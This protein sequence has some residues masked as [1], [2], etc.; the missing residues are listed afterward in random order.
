MTDSERAV[1]ANITLALLMPA[2]RVC[3]WQ[4]ELAAQIAMLSGIDVDVLP[5]V[6]TPRDDSQWSALA[7]STAALAET[8]PASTKPSAK[9]TGWDVVLDLAGV[10][11]AGWHGRSVHGVWQLL[12]AQGVAL[13]GIFPAY[14]AIS[15]GNG[16]EL[17]LVRDGDAVLNTIRFFGDPRY[18]DA[19]ARLYTYASILVCGPLQELVATGERP[20]VAKFQ[21]LPSLMR[22]QRRGCQLRQQWTLLRRR[23]ASQF[24]SESWMIGVIDA[25][26]KDLLSK[27]LPWDVKW[28]GPRD[29]NYYRADPFGVPG[30]DDRFYCEVF[31]YR[32][33]RGSLEMI[34][35]DDA[36]QIAR[37]EPAQLSLSGH[38]SYPYLFEHA[39]RTYGIPET[40]GRN[41][42]E[43][44][45]LTEDGRWL[46][47]ATLLHDVA[48]IDASLFVWEGRFWLAYTDGAL[49][50]YNNLCL[51]YAS[52]LAGPW[53]RH[54][55][56]P[57]K[58]DHRSSRS[59]GTPF[60]HG[61]ALY[62]PAQDCGSGYGQAVVIN[63]ITQ[64]TP[65]TFH[66][67][68]VR[69]CSP[70]PRG[71]NPDGLHTLSAWGARTLVD[72][73]KYIFSPAELARKLR[74]RIARVSKA[75]A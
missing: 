69:V 48:A 58:M 25:P 44:F 42:C 62:R 34:E 43:L 18:K 71:R 38:Q 15:A 74:G 59:A 33:G 3:R 14:E 66:E 26:I 6:Y 23:I 51:I 16:A 57:V 30:R 24:L 72:G 8:R 65:T 41:C 22:W 45:E 40:A 54:A 5:V 55:Q 7:T 68:V 56:Y 39:G 32:E 1:M 75:H 19:F 10:D 17:F 64:C 49:G 37:V 52:D 11:P 67:E 47:I 13:A 27:P 36:G 53:Q 20:V 61:G 70:D 73:K 21:P 46:R 12:D 35:L 50:A 31:D 60:M 29:R 63:R 2:E 28:L 9:N 4:E